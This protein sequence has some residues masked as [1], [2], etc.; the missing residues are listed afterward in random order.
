[1]LVSIRIPHT[2]VCAYVRLYQQVA[3]VD[4]AYV[5]LYQQVAQVCLG[6]KCFTQLSMKKKMNLITF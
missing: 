3:Q 5:C 6:N 2:Q 4:C 1:M